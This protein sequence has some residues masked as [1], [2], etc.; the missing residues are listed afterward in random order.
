MARKSIVGKLRIIGFVMTF[1]ALAGC[2]S[3]S[4]LGGVKGTADRALQTANEAQSSATAAN[5]AASDASRKDD[6]IAMKAD[7]AADAAQSAS[8]KVDV[9]AQQM[10]DLDEKMDRMFKKGMQK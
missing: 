2:A 1:C 3:S 5:A 10:K 7:R 4:D 8:S 9:L 6:V